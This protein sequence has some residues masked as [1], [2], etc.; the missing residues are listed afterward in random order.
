[1]RRRRIWRAIAM[2]RRKTTTPTTTWKTT[3]KTKWRNKKR[4]RRRVLHTCHSRCHCSGEWER[5][6]FSPAVGFCPSRIQNHPGR[7][8]GGQ[9]SSLWM[10]REPDEGQDQNLIRIKIW[11]RINEG[12]KNHDEKRMIKNDQELWQG[13]SL[14][15][16]QGSPINCSNSKIVSGVGEKSIDGARRLCC[17]NPLAWEL[18]IRWEQDSLVL[19]FRLT[20]II[21]SNQKDQED[22]V[23]WE[24]QIRWEQ[25]TFGLFVFS[26]SNW[27]RPSS[28]SASGY[29]IIL[30]MTSC[31]S[32]VRWC[33]CEVPGAQMMMINLIIIWINLII[34]IMIITWRRIVFMG[35]VRPMLANE[36]KHWQT[37]LLP[38]RWP[39]Y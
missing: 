15:L 10:G 29:S 11:I 31:D 14:S 6:D 9:G 13:S 5:P 32:L 17:F 2:M 34:L 3:W 24:L 25:N 27:P 8:W 35:G 1:M 16:R 12:K 21:F 39:R 33:L 22:S 37:M 38:R 7:V 23:A 19:K 26:C 4:R 36:L 28:L 30:A 20:K 18:Q